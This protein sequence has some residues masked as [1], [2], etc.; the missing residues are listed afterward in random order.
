MRTRANFKV[1]PQF[2]KIRFSAKC[3]LTTREGDFEMFIFKESSTAKEHVVMVCGTI[4]RELPTLVRLHS[5]C[6]TGE[7]MSSLHCECGPQLNH[8]LKLMQQNGSG[9]LLYLRQEGRG[10]GLT[11]KV[12]QYKLMRDTGIDTMEAAIRVGRDRPDQRSYTFC[13][14]IFEF[15]G[16]KRVRLVTNNSKKIEA[17]E[18]M[19]IQVVERVPIQTGMCS[20][21]FGYLKTKAEKMGHMFDENFLQNGAQVAE[22]EIE[23]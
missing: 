1:Q 10:M 21:N 17:V 22:N 16:V 5:E 19:G 4:D 6:F 3:T 14:N 12:L 7:V 23:Y 20:T 11:S 2:N 13:K 18:E 15:F 8:T 9:M